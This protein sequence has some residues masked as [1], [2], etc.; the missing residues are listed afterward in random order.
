MPALFINHL[1]DGLWAYAFLS[2][3]LIIWNRQIHIPWLIVVLISFVAFE[4]LQS[5]EIIN[6]TGDIKDIITYCT[7]SIIALFAN[8]FF[9]KTLNYTYE[10]SY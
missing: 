5:L 6:G 8:S 10:T 9:S 4:V 3:I 7:F 2:C 1:P